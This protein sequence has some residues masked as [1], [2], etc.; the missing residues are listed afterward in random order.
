VMG[1]APKTHPPW[2]GNPIPR[3]RSGQARASKICKL[4]NRSRACV[5]DSA[6]GAPAMGGESHPS[7][8]LGTSPRLQRHRGPSLRSG[9]R[10]G[11]RRRAVASSFRAG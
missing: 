3:V 7:R 9:F 5:M 1:S 10:R 2:A 4:Q 8:A 11:L 6:R